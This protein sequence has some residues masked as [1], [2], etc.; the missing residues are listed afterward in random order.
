MKKWITVK[1]R[2]RELKDLEKYEIAANVAIKYGPITRKG[3][4]GDYFSE[5]SGKQFDSFL[6]YRDLDKKKI[7]WFI[8]KKIS[9]DDKVWNADYLAGIVKCGKISWH[10]VM[11]PTFSWYYNKNL[12]KIFEESPFYG[13]VNEEVKTHK[14]PNKWIYV[15]ALCLNPRFDTLS[16]IAGLL[17]TGIKEERKDGFTYAKYTT[18]VKKEIYKFGIPIEFSK[19]RYFYISPFWPLCFGDYMANFCVDYWNNIERPFRAEEY[20]SIL[21]YILE[22]PNIKAGGLPFLPSRR[23]VFNRFQSR[24]LKTKE[25]IENHYISY[26]LINLHDIIKKMIVGSIKESL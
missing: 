25:N 8:N 1:K 6:N 15:P 12:C 23:T 18:K 5:F 13:T 2:K 22:S 3:I 26:G 11:F 10:K 7:K 14:V 19:K 9:F 20:S 16:Y 17:S 21:W 24:D 4:K